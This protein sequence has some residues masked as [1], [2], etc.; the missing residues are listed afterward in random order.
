[1]A[2]TVG[3][4]TK[5]TVQPA[6]DQFDELVA[7]L[8]NELLVKDGI[9]VSTIPGYGDPAPDD[10][11]TSRSGRRGAPPPAG[12]EA[13]DSLFTDMYGDE[14]DVP[15]PVE[16]PEDESSYL[17]NIGRGMAGRAAALGGGLAEGSAYAWRKMG[18]LTGLD[19]S[20]IVNFMENVALSGRDA[21]EG[22]YGYD[23]ERNSWED[24]KADYAGESDAGFWETAGNT[25]AFGVEQG[26]ISL[27]D[28]VAAVTMLPAYM[29]MRTGEIAG[30]RARADGRSEVDTSDIA[31]GAVTAA[32]VSILE[33][34]GA[35][36]LLPQ[37]AATGDLLRD[38]L[39]GILRGGS[40]E[41]LTEFGQELAEFVGVNTLTEKSA[42]MSGMEY[43][44][45]MV[46]QALA[47]L[48]GG[49]TFGG[50]AGGA[51]A[52]G[53]SLLTG[54]EA[55]LDDGSDPDGPITNEKGE[56]YDP[57]TD[58]FISKEEMISEGQPTDDDGMVP[59]DVP[60]ETVEDDPANQATQKIMGE[61]GVNVAADQAA[62]V[63]ARVDALDLPEG[64]TV[65]TK[66]ESDG[67]I[68]FKKVDAAEQTPAEG[69]EQPDAAAAE[70][71]PPPAD[72]AAET[73]PDA[74]PTVEGASEEEATVDTNV[75]PEQVEATPEQ[76]EATPEQVEEAPTAPSQPALD[77]EVLNPENIEINAAAADAAKAL[78]KRLEKST[79][80]T[81]E[82]EKVV[83]GVIT[84]M[85]RNE[86]TQRTANRIRT[87]L[88]E[89]GT[90][91]GFNKGD[92]EQALEKLESADELDVQATLEAVGFLV[93][94]P[95]S[96]RWGEHVR[97]CVQPAA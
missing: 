72:V 9:D 57:E 56:I 39:G 43:F 42:D 29:T 65:E 86:P 79:Q 96:Q 82:L 75:A 69:V 53:E 31:T 40:A 81:T 88:N 15:P 67:S 47:G 78:K 14:L 17:G 59:I 3:P 7:E 1:M 77:A 8:E 48:V 22:Y 11:S 84:D 12:D 30:D 38:T 90:R 33:K 26:L 6:L 58:T 92:K 55:P 73:A 95:L 21:Q 34:F 74:T 24:L 5:D 20:P 28:M 41:G 87:A 76:V 70:T 35:E 93:G 2:G 97:G 91:R 66:V 64:T 51:T 52:A 62:D 85:E 50:V 27:P 10:S 23:A 13:W 61:G 89:F 63:Q 68:T 94:K 71:T 44:L 83:Q 25:I 45:E 32:A 80:D 54:G 16:E 46:D 19:T 4:N 49:G 18:D 36:K 60:E 37:G